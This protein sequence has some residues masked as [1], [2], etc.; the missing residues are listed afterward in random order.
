MSSNA[1]WHYLYGSRWQRERAEFLLRNPI[2]AK[3]AERDIVVAATVVDHREP[4][5]GDESLFWR[6]SNWQALCKPC[7]DGEKQREERG[8]QQLGADA[9]GLPV[10]PHH[11]WNR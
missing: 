9:A 2:C 4:H 10:D 6:R 3:H 5:K 8:T 1:R 7:H 11:H